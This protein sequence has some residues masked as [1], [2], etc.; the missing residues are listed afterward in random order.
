[1]SIKDFRLTEE[2]AFLFVL[3]YEYGLSFLTLLKLYELS[4][5]FNKFYHETRILGEEDEEKRAGY[6]A[7]LSLCLDILETCIDLLGF[8][9]PEK[10]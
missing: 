7:L 9:A 2:T 3:S 1:M 4:D 6:I 8:D 5:T 10:M